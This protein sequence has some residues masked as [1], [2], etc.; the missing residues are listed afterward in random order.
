MTMDCQF[1]RARIRETFDDKAT[2]A[3]DATVATHLADCPTCS[4]FARRLAALDAQ[5]VQ[6]LAPPS[7]SPAFRTGLEARIKKEP[8]PSRLDGLLDLVHFASCALA[9]LVL[10]LILPINSAAVVAVGV[11]A[12]LTSYV[13]LSIVR[14]S[15]DDESLES[16]L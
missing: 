1:V 10:A 8:G 6:T 14:G 16:E 9:T 5:L 7:L 3:A 11:T 12:A 4:A 13:A 15:F 2:L